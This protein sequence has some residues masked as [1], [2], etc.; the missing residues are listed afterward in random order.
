MDPKKYWDERLKSHWD[1][2]GVGCL[3]LGELNKYV[4][5]AKV[6]TLERA[7]RK[8]HVDFNGKEVLDVGSGTGFWIITISAK[9]SP[10][11]L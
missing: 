2:E 11:N 5:M 7:A 8:L 6:R 10:K 4:Y 9:K 3:G 1:L